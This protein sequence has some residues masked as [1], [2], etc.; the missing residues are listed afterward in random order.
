[1]LHLPHAI[2]GRPPLRGQWSTTGQ[3]DE[4]T[5][6]E[7]DSMSPFGVRSLSRVVTGGDG[8]ASSTAA[9]TGIVQE[10]LI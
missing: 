8:Y 5:L 3:R 6:G 7:R 10:H 2:I 1:M 4:R 9:L